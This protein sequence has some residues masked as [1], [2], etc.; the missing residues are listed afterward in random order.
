MAK[1]RTFNKEKETKNQGLH[2][3]WRGIG[4]VINLLSPIISAAAAVA[5][6]DFGKAQNWPFLASLSG[7]VTFP[8]V[9]YRIPWIGLVANYLSSIPYFGAMFMFFVMF[10]VLFSSVFALINAILYR[11]IGPPRYS[12]IDAPAPRVKTKRYTR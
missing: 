2:P 3:V 7:T 11:M 6:V 8:A 10:L 9:I 4:L 1:F 12:P 5:L